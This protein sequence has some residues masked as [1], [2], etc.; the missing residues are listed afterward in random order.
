MLLLIGRY[1]RDV[2]LPPSCDR[3][4]R[5]QHVAHINWRR[6]YS[7][8][9]FF[10]FPLFSFGEQ[11]TASCSVCGYTVMGRPPYP[12]PKMPFLDRSGVLVP[13]VGLAGA[14]MAFFVF[15]GVAVAT[16]PPPAPRTAE[17]EE[18]LRLESH[19]MSGETWGEGRGAQ[20][21]ADAV[22]ATLVHDEGFARKDVGAI[23]QIIDGSPRR[24][25]VDIRYMGLSEMKPTAREDLVLYLHET[26]KGKLHENDRVV[27]TVQGVLLTGILAQGT[28]ESEWTIEIGTAIEEKKVLAALHR[29]PEADAGANP[30]AP[31]ASSAPS[32]ASAPA[33]PA[34]VDPPK[35]TPKKKKKPTEAARPRP[36]P[37]PASA[38]VSDDVAP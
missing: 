33:A 17:Q 36:A 9:H 37:S 8:V 25:F 19:L 18:L 23:A 15:I 6:K 24:V 38:L 1:R 13:M 12:I 30:V 4:P 34:S 32:A 28:A 26:M 35:K 3:C 11:F 27:V 21:L 7:T 16:A 2:M 5:C 14:M 29:V 22:V 20:E 10:F 31:T